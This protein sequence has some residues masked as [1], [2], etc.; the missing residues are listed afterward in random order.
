MRPHPANSAGS[1]EFKGIPHEF[2]LEF[3]DQLA[4]DENPR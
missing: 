4:G 2:R 3:A 1:G